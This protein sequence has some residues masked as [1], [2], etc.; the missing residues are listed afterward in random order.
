MI[1]ETIR[2]FRERLQR[3]HI[4]TVFCLLAVVVCFVLNSLERREAQRERMEYAYYVAADGEVIP[5]RYAQRR[6]NLEIEIRHHL[7]MFVDAWYSLTQYDWQQKAEAAGWLGGNS[8]RDLFVG[9]QKAG[10]YNRFIQNNIV[11]RARIEEMRIRPESD[12]TFSFELVIGMQ[13]QSDA[14]ARTWRV[15]SEGRVRVIDRS[16]PHNPH[17]LWIEPYLETKI[18]EVKNDE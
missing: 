17:G 3:N 2:S 5:A 18:M 8:I 16:W 12:G 15:L 9:R 13:E 6:D 7:T 4:V 11:Q 14:Y 10:Y 1:P